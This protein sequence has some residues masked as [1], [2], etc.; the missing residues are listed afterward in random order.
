MARRPAAAGEVA[1]LLGIDAGIG[2]V[3]RIEDV[4]QVLIIGAGRLEEGKAVLSRDKPLCQGAG[5]LAAIGE[6]LRP[7]TLGVE[8]VEMGFGDVDSNNIRVYDHGACP[9]DARS[10]ASSL[11]Q[12]FRLNA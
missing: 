8:D 4:A 1:G 5:G 6:A 3:P 11:V 7:P 9:C 2:D 10:G 12:L